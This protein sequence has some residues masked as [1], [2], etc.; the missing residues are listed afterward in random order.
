MAKKQMLFD[1]EARKALKD[2]ADDLADTIRVTLGPKGRN[3]I[4]DK[5]FG[6]PTIS[7]DG[8]TI[9]KDI[10]LENPYR[11][12]GARM[13]RE[14]VTETHDQVGG[15]TATSTLL[16]QCIIREGVKN[17]TW[18][19]NPMMLKKGIDK[20]V[21]TVVNL[22]K[23]RSKEVETNDQIVQVATVSANNDIEIGNLIA[24][25][26]EKVGKDGVITVEE[27]TGV[28]TG[29]EVVEGMQFD[30]GYISAYM[31]TD[32]D[33]ME[34]VLE[35]PCILIYGSKI[36]SMQPLLP[37]LQK[38]IQLARPILIIAEDVEGE[39]LATLVVNKLRGG[40]Q[41]AAVKSPGYGDRRKEMMADIAVSTGGQVISEELGFRLENVVVGMLGQA[42]RII[43]DKDSTTIIGGSGKSEEIKGRAEQ[44]RKQIDETT[45]DYDKEKL[46]E[47]L[48]RLTSGVAIVNVG[49]P[50]ETALKEKKARV[51]DALAATKAAIEEG[52]VV[53]GGVALL[54][55]VDELDKMQM[56]GD[57][58]IGVEII[59]RALQEPIRCIASNAGVD[60]SVVVSQVKDMEENFGFNALTGQ[61][62]DLMA[63]GVVDPVK[64]VCAA[65]RNAASIAGTMLTTQAV[66]T[67][68][69]EEEP[70]SAHHHG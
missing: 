4:L 45:S 7:S 21:E 56:S 28:E 22:I 33:N 3:V 34:A 46:Q 29:I 32:V 61:I 24:E 30:R 8:A 54:R 63:A 68:I 5:K 64:T 43:V 47:R 35:N 11:N 26:M 48:A 59:K 14:A 20:A 40:L 49:A 44:I 16:A 55:A 50:T 52:I 18:G 65:L 17:L 27:A 38:M 66:V 23:S 19:A 62:E 37:I 36:S 57:E 60:G 15:G 25:A 13:V 58:A 70:P 1:N 2:G 31:V 67:E 69:P 12:M 10:E 39:A 6:S 9:A 41:C 51:E 53:G 42:K